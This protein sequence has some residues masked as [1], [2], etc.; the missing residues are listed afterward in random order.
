MSNGRDGG[1]LSPA[2]RPEEPGS[3]DAQ[4]EIASIQQSNPL[5]F[6]D[7]CLA[8]MRATHL[9]CAIVLSRAVFR[10]PQGELLSNAVV[11]DY[12]GLLKALM[13]DRSESGRFHA[14]VSFAALAAC[15]LQMTR[16]QPFLGE[17]REWLDSENSQWRICGLKA[18]NSV[19]KSVSFS[20]PEMAELIVPLLQIIGTNVCESELALRA[21]AKCVKGLPFL[22]DLSVFFEKVMAVTPSFVSLAFMVWAKVMDRHCNL[23]SPD[24]LSVLIEHGFVFAASFPK[25]CIHVLRFFIFFAF[26]EIEE[27]T[28]FLVS[29]FDRLFEMAFFVIVAGGHGNAEFG[30]VCK[31]DVSV[32]AE[33]LLASL[34]I[35]DIEMAAY[36]SFPLIE[37]NL[38]SSDVCCRCAAVIGYFSLIE[39]GFET[40]FASTVLEAAFHSRHCPTLRAGLQILSIIATQQT[41]NINYREWLTTVLT[42]FTQE[43][44]SI[45]LHISGVVSSIVNQLMQ[46]QLS[47]NVFALIIEL[48]PIARHFPVVVD[49]I[50]V[51]I[52]HVPDIQLYGVFYQ[53]A[54]SITNDSEVLICICHLFMSLMEVTGCVPDDLVAPLFEFFI[55]LSRSYCADSALRAIGHMAAILGNQFGGFVDQSMFAI[56][57]HLIDSDDSVQASLSAFLLI[58][59]SCNVIDYLTVLLPMCFGILSDGNV[60]LETQI[61]VLRLIKSTVLLYWSYAQSLLSQIAGIVISAYSAFGSLVALDEE[62]ASSLLITLFECMEATAIQFGIEVFWGLFGSTFPSVGKDIMKRV[63][64]LLKILFAPPDSIGFLL[65]K[66]TRQA[67]P[68]WAGVWKIALT[69]VKICL[70]L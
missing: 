9:S 49:L 32:A 4:L 15:I 47:Y 24:V 63:V 5:G 51:L 10:R 30:E 41:A 12:H 3:T 34:A 69:L 61:V 28:V 27:R 54:L 14:L 35:L 22:H 13:A 39:A 57:K 31:W 64:E 58:M 55:E 62:I 50:G 68:A 26:H 6:L 60:M 44:E 45:H 59:N 38:R 53:F 36:V 17:I 16:E 18:L 25:D 42:L 11:T 43:F 37:C 20:G 46:L 1:V 52:V 7:L 2:S 19:L 23:F 70:G 29:F 65:N 66:G 48:L 33:S 40:A 67:R 8:V 56:Q 21:L